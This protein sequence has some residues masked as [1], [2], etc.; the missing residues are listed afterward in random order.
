LKVI[1][2]VD[3]FFTASEILSSDGTHSR[4]SVTGLKGTRLLARR[5]IIKDDVE[6]AGRRSPLY[7]TARGRSR[8]NW[9]E[10]FI[11]LNLD[12]FFA[13]SEADKQK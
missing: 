3:R 1:G 13:A 8:D 6:V 4:I 12:D 11:E 5:R 10:R 7:G 2:V 9:C